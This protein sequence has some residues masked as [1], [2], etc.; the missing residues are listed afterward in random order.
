[1]K[2]KRSSLAIMAMTSLIGTACSNPLKLSQH[3]LPITS[4]IE[5]VN[6]I[7]TSFDLPVFTYDHP[8]FGKLGLIVSERAID[9]NN[10]DQ[11][12]YPG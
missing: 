9:K 2:V 8:D 1:M 7:E 10:D 12:D 6:G 3:T 5:S 11:F 4:R